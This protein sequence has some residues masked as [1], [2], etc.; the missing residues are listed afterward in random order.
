MNKDNSISVPILSIETSGNLCGA[1]IYFSEKKY[2]EVNFNLKN[3]HAEKLFDAIDFVIKSAGID[4]KEVG[5]IAVSSGPGSF[6]G[7]RIG[8]SAAK[9][10]SFGANLPII[11]VCTFEALALQITDFLPE[12]SKFSIANKVNVEEIYFAKFQIKKT[13]FIYIDD[14]QIIN[15]KDLHA[16]SENTITFGNSLL[17]SFNDFKTTI[18]SPSPFYVAKFAKEFGK[19]LLTFDYDYLEPSY[20]KNFIVKEPKN[21]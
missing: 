10:L 3:S 19:K 6:T 18:S 17:N 14:L 13:K 16:K 1:C 8:M 7:L 11:P 21:V 20:F 2:F 15:H 12:N 9:G 4:L 5:A